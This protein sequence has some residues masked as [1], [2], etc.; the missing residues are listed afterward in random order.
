MAAKVM[1]QPAK[2]C[3]VAAHM[4]GPVSRLETPQVMGKGLGER[5]YGA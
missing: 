4:G 5:G 2:T 3:K 1:S